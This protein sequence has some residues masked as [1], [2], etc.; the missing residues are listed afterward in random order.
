MAPHSSA[1]RYHPIRSGASTGFLQPQPE[2]RPSPISLDVV[3]HHCSQDSTVSV[4]LDLDVL[5]ILAP[6]DQ[7]AA[8]VAG[9]VALPIKDFARVGRPTKA[10][11]MQL[12]QGLL[13]RRGECFGAVAHPAWRLA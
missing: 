12:T 2:G 5:K 6:P 10:R 7:R 8:D 4:H 3:D 9:D 11:R 1:P 13:I